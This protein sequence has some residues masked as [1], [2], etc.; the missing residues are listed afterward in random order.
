[1]LLGGTARSPDD[2]KSLQELGLDFAEISIPDIERFGKELPL[3][4]DL[5]DESR[6]LYL[7]H[8]PQEGDPND[9]RALENVYFPKLL[10]VV[11]LANQLRSRTL[12]IHL[13]M[14][15]RFVHEDV[16]FYKTGF[17]KRLLQASSSYHLHVNIENLSE[18]A[19][20]LL[21]VF[22]AV[23]ELGLTLDIGHAQ[24]LTS[25]NRSFE[26]MTDCPER[27]R[28]VHI[29]DNNGGT[30]SDDDL[31]LPVGKGNIDFSPVLEGLREIG[32]RGTMTLEL[33]PQ[34][35]ENCLDRVVDILKHVS[36]L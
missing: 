17:L 34:E 2:V 15:P 19:S 30:S 35:I 36:L 32:Y 4:L 6:F 8:G 7:S 26:F 10:E 21:P 20:D 9:I 11:R 27:I 3:Y 14:D 25:K 12:T 18:K 23:P 1:M 22:E 29:H 31:H 28:H 16:I 24:L 5:L 33:R 13:W